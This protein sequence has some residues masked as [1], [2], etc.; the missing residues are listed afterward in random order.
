MDGVT[1]TNEIIDYAI[2]EKKEFLLF[3][4]DFSQGY[5]CKDWEFLRRMSKNVGFGD[6]WMRWLEGGVFNIS[7]SILVNV[8]STEEFSVCRGLR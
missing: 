5:D 8:N 7:M 2:R 4:V 1:I 6:R 3:K